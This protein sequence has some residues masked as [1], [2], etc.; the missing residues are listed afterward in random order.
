METEQTC[1][2]RINKNLAR[3][4]ET[5]RDLWAGYS[6]GDDDKTEEFYNYGL[7]FDYVRGDDGDPGYFR[8]QL[9]WGGPSDEFRFYVDP[10]FVCYKVEYA[11]LNWFD[12]ATRRL[13]NED[14]EFMLEI[15]ENFKD[16]GT[17]EHVFN[18]AIKD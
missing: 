11:F 9:S 15:F 2:Q 1:E 6:E 13:Y 3:E 16:C 17:V 4:L 14:K 7:S 18:K 12:G 10:D 5:L 8:Y